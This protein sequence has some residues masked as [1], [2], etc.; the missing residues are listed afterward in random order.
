MT[1]EA[2]STD[3]FGPFRVGL[4]RKRRLRISSLGARGR[5]ILAI[6]LCAF[7]LAML[8]GWAMATSAPRPWLL[9]LGSSLL[10]I[11]AVV[12]PLLLLSYISGAYR[13]DTIIRGSMPAMAAAPAIGWA[14][15]WLIAK[16]LETKL[17][18]G[19]FSTPHVMWA[20]IGMLA[21][22]ITTWTTRSLIRSLLRRREATALVV[23][24]GDGAECRRIATDM[25]TRGR[26]DPILA[27]ATDGAADPSPW[28][29][30][31]ET[32]G[33]IGL[34]H[35][36]RGPV[37]CMVC[38]KPWDGLPRGQQRLLIHARLMNIPVLRP[39]DFYEEL[40]ARVP[41]HFADASWMVNDGR[42]HRQEDPAF[43]GS[44]R[45]LDLFL[46]LVG[47]VFAALPM[48]LTAIAVRLTSPGPIFFRQQRTGQ[49]ER[50]F[51]IL[52]FRT[53]RVDAEK[54]GARWA[55]KNDP[56][57]T[58]IGAFLR[59]SRLDELPQLW[60]VLI[61]DMSLVGPRPERPEFNSKLEHEIPFYNLRHLAKPGLTGWAQINYSYGASV[62]DAI[63]KLEFDIWYVKNATVLLD[64]RIILRTIMVVLGLRGR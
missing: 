13:S 38:T 28:P 58:P 60:N 9:G 62:E 22:A 42:L 49:W 56:R 1:A 12:S 19:S 53:M 44:K 64:L 41:V 5:L 29:E 20:I 35:R 2:L 15:A 23:L 16:A 6:S 34:L 47:L 21:A 45:I 25:R 63:A 31:V 8:A 57:V 52:K 24:L 59:K 46:T 55:S 32:C 48:L 27:V 11:I 54:D 61:G 50:D 30:R 26:R 36:L 4:G 37:H 14:M 18:W 33:A 7:D 40:W 39:A 10:G 51:T 3:R 43:V 17:G